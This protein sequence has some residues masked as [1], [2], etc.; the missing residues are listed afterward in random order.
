[1]NAIEHAILTLAGLAIGATVAHWTSHLLEESIYGIT[2]T[3]P[4]AYLAAT[5]IFLTIATLAALIP[6]RRATTIQPT[7]ALRHD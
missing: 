3:D 4:P 6:A 5:A 1:M 2:P 7:E